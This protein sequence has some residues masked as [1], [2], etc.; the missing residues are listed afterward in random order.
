M[1]RFGT[2]KT[3]AM[4]VKKDFFLLDCSITL[5]KYLL[6]SEMQINP[7]KVDANFPKLMCESKN[8]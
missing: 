1:Y 8:I 3:F 5:I 7:I 6:N 4:I 2:L